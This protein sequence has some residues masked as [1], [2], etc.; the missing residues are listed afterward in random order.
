MIEPLDD[1]M[2]QCFNRYMYFKYKYELLKEKKE[3]L[4]SNLFKEKEEDEYGEDYEDE[5]NDIKD[6]L[7]KF[8]F[9]EHKVAADKTGTGTDSGLKMREKMDANVNTNKENDHVP[10][11]HKF[12]KDG[13]NEI[14]ID[15]N[16][17]FG[18]NNDNLKKTSYSSPWPVIHEDDA[19]DIIEEY[20]DNNS[21]QFNPSQITA[22]SLNM[23]VNKKTHQIALN[24][25]PGFMTF[26]NSVKV[27]ENQ[28]PVNGVSFDMFEKIVGQNIE[29]AL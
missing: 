10:E 26:Y 17:L 5:D 23:D 13:F 29:F 2:K 27:K 28:F 16:D 24:T 20:I 14:T 25:F 9:D 7:S 21:D 1:K 8:S 4:S 11:G 3:R 6:V 12:E 15:G 22:P 18:E 19:K